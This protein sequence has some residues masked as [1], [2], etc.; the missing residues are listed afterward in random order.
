MQEAMTATSDSDLKERSNDISVY[1]S[2]SVL[3]IPVI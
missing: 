1:L 3:E 2:I